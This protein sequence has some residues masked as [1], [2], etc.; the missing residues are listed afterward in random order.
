MTDEL[1]ITL[2]ATGLFLGAASA[3]GV[4]RSRFRGWQ[5]AALVSGAFVVGLAAPVS[6]ALGL[7]AYRNMT[8]PAPNA[9]VQPGPAT[10]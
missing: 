3:F 9:F 1:L 10:K 6:L 4:A 7:I 2:L 5:R 8:D